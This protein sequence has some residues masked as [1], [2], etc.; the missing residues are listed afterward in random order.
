MTP[1]KKV[2]SR[3]ERSEWRDLSCAVDG[4]AG[5]MQDPLKRKS[6]SNGALGVFAG[7]GEASAATLK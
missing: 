6:R 7:A 1:T 4:D 5:E 3:P 2:S